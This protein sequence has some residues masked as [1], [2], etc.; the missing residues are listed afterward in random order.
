VRSLP[1]FRL[2]T[3]LPGGHTVGDVIENNSATELEKES[4]RRT[5][6]MSFAI[7]PEVKDRLARFRKEGGTI[8]V[9][10]LCNEAIERELNRLASG[11]SVLQRLRVELTARRGQSWTLGFQ[12]GRKWA[13]EKA[14][15]LE[16]TDYATR[17]T[18]LD[19]KVKW[20]NSYEQ[21][22]D[23]VGLF[24]APA[25]DYVYDGR[26]SAG[27]PSFSYLTDDLETKWEASIWECETYWQGW[28]KAVHEVYHEN[29]EHLPSVVDQL[30]PRPGD[31]QAP[32]GSDD[33]P[34][35]VDPDEIPF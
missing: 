4:P 19:V 2:L 20:E 17:T 29:K 12:E 22:V 13:E 28:L 11:G 18:E 32:N 21:S 23:F 24:R 26:E 27:A 1:V 15:W 25:R 7:R 31:R 6:P 30:P 14:S 35:D 16:I 10:G 5:E 3:P 33:V 8:N 34:R 9:S